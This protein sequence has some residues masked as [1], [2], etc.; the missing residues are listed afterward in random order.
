MCI[1]QRAFDPIFVLAMEEEVY[2]P[3]K[4][5]SLTMR[6]LVIIVI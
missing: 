6:R 4:E 1:Y 5:K 3:K 2:D